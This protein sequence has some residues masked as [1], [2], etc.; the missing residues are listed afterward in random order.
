MGQRL[1]NQKSQ[2]V[3]KKKFTLIELLVIIAIIAILLTLLLPSLSKAREK[4]KAALCMSNS[5]Q[6]GQ[7]FIRLTLSNKFNTKNNVVYFGND[8]RVKTTK[9][10]YSNLAES[11]IRVLMKE[12]K[13]PNSKTINSGWGQ[14]R[15][16]TSGLFYSKINN[17]DS[18]IGWGNRKGFY[19]K[20]G[21]KPLL[22]TH[23]GKDTVWMFDGHAQSVTW[24]HILNTNKSPNLLDD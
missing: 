15:Y 12:L 1:R 21:K 7:M 20:L 2:K 9:M 24:E 5:S 23:L 18:F 4:A 10:S 3:M 13:C 16:V 17:P 22:E 11:E 19:A 6:F 8:W 14:N